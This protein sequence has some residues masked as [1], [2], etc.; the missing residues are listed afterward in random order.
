MTGLAFQGFLF[1]LICWTMARE[2]KR[3]PESGFFRP[4]LMGFAPILVISIVSFTVMQGM[5][6]DELAKAKEALAAQFAALL[7]SQS[8]AAAF[9]AEELQMITELSLRLQPAAVSIFWLAILTLAALGLRKWLA[10]K[11]QTKIAEPLSRWRAPDFLI[12][13]LFIPAAILLLDQRH[14]LGKVE[15]WIRDLSQNMVIIMLAIYLFQGMMVLLEK[16]SRLGMPKPVVA[17]LLS[18]ALVMAL[19]PAGRGIALG[20]LML[21]LLDTWF[22]FRK[23]APKH[24]DDDERSKP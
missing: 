17:L 15:V 16:I 9:T 19:L 18:S 10:E 4:V 14:W 6:A 12:W 11:G 20:L 8:G 5:K 23:L 2:M 21:G 7:G 22:N 13:M 3:H 1:I 24:G